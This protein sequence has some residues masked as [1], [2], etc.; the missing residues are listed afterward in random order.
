MI[1]TSARYASA[2]VKAKGRYPHRDPMRMR[3][4]INI[5]AQL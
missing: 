3:I 5:T 2:Y 4:D 1:D